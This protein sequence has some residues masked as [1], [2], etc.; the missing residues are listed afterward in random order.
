MFENGVV[1]GEKEV[2]GEL[3]RTGLRI[4]ILQRKI[5]G[6]IFGMLN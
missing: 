5:L 6:W 1:S 4:S 3:G 2:I